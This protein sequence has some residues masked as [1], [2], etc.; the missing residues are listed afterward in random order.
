MSRIG[1]APIAVPSSVNVTIDGAVVHVNGPRGSLSQSFDP[2]MRILKE[3]DV[4]R[5]E[6]PSDERE[7]RALHGLTRSLLANMVEGVTNGYERRLEIVGVGYRATL[8][9]SDLEL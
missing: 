1:K 4:L 9:G 8:K 5:V 7:H 2:D 3:D 6:R